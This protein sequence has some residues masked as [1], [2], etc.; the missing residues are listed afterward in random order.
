MYSYKTSEKL[1]KILLKLSKKNK[2][3]YEQILRKIN[4]VANSYDVEIY[5]NL[6]HNMKD[7]K[8]VQI[9]HFVLIFTFN[10]QLNLIFFENFDHHDNIYK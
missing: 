1:D 5:K 7:F 10:K 8:R 9:G 4:D 2:Q 3:L 6:R